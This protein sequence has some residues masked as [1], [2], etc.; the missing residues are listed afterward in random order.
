MLSF[1]VV[2][3]FTSIPLPTA[4]RITNELLTTNST[5][6]N[7]TQLSKTDILDLL[8]LCLSTEFQFEET[9]YRQTSGTPMGS[10]LSSFLTEAV[11]QDLERQ[12]LANNK[13]VKLW[14]RYIDD[15]MS[16]AKTHHIENLFHTINTTDGITFTMEK[17]KDGQIAFMDI[18]ITRTDNGSI[19]TDVYRKRT[20]TDQILNY[21]SNH[22]TQQKVSCLKT[23]LNRIDTHCSTT[24]SKKKELDYLYDTF[25]KNNYPKHFIDSVYKR[26]RQN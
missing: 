3:L 4:R 6:T 14:D 11:M 16:I 25:R 22:P 26:R 10:P 5:W 23:L 9:F 12:A 13:N 1:D 15:A 8:D 20:H 24:E 2:S 19:E 7:N 18:K 17:E 21:N